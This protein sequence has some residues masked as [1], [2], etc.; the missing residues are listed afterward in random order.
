MK[1]SADFTVFCMFMLLIYITIN[2]DD[3]V[4]D[5]YNQVYIMFTLIFK[6]ANT[7]IKHDN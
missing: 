4:S 3:I 7:I 2:Q 6:S 1:Y 5:L